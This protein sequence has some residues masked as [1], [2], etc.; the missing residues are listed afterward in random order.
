M[1]TLA[2]PMLQQFSDLWEQLFP[3]AVPSGIVGDAAH[4]L[5]GGYHI[6]IEDQPSS[7]Y[8]VIRLDDKAPPGT[9]SREASAAVDMSLALPDMKT[10]DS[11]VDL[12]FMSRLDPR[13]VF[14]NAVNCWDG[15]DS[16]GRFDMVSNT[17]STASDDHKWHVHLEFRRRY[18]NDLNA[19]SAV[20][21][22][23][24]GET[25]K[26]WLDAGGVA[27]KPPPYTPLLRRPWP[28]Y[29]KAGY[30]F[31]LVNGPTPSRGGFYTYEQPDV[32]AIQR[33]VTALG[34]HAEEDGKFGLATRAA[35]S[36]WQRAKY[37]STTS[38]YGEVW[39][40]DWRHLFTY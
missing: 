40:D 8:S 14:L 36:S 15:N 34:F 22:V 30:F 32:R 33:R 9:W 19:M 39:G 28:R 20:L 21:S 25:P 6:S 16:P 3:T 2:T 11:R 1:T 26:Q 31:G 24:K 29:M 37:K 5:R 13:R 10:V 23:L 38:R 4:A 17:I 7:N 12:L 35:V 27:I 18:A